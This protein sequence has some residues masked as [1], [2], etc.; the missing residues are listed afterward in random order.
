VAAS[1][2]TVEHELGTVR[3][4][5]N[6]L[7]WIVEL[8][9][10]VRSL[11]PAERDA[12]VTALLLAAVDAAAAAGGGR[13]EVW[14]HE[15]RPDEDDAIVAAGFHPYRDLW[16][17]RCPL[18]AAPTDLPVR[19]F[20][21]ADA[22]AFLE[23]NNRAF[24]W[25]P[26]Q[27]GLTLDDLRATQSEPWYDPSGFLLHDQIVDGR[28]RLAAFCWTKVH[29]EHEP[30]LGEIYA[31]AV[32]PDFHGRKLGGPMTLAGLQWLA[33]QGLRHGMLYVE[34]DNHAANRVYERLGFH[35]H[36]T[37]RAYERTAEPA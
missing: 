27:G 16:Q 7:G 18:P 15:V 29:A 31:I 21:D 22:E 2:R 13:L 32:D 28:P 6:R 23:V 20:T 34:S 24:H 1:P 17:L 33:E 12:A 11:P 30:P 8:P 37:D 3:L 36:H 10:D 19:P 5:P 9:A 35:H 14:R 25:H 26:E 4:E